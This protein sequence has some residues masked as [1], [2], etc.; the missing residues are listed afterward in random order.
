LMAL[1]IS[2]KNEV[3]TR[4]EIMNHV[5]KD[6]IVSEDSVSKAASD[7]RKFFQTNHMNEFHLVTIPKLG[8]KLEIS[9]SKATIVRNKNLIKRPLKIIGFALLGLIIS[10]ILIRAARY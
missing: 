9:Q 2:N 6:L 4:E 5:W 8:Y 3:V 1:L 7:L 10:I